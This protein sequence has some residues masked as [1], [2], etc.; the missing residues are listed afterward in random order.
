MLKSVMRACLSFGDED[1]TIT[2][3]IEVSGMERHEI[4]PRLRLLQNAGLISKTNTRWAPTEGGR[5]LKEIWYRNTELLA[6]SLK[7]R[8]KPLNAPSNSWDKMWKVVRAL[9]RFTRNDLAVICEQSLGNVQ[10]FTIRYRQHG[11]LRCL[12]KAGTK[13]PIWIL[14]KDPGPLRPLGR[15]AGVDR[16]SQKRS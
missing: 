1:Y 9:R 4:K 5:P 13:N 14:L 2:Q 7:P 6:A 16:N 11:Y 12:G 10:R 8:I 15:N 3:I